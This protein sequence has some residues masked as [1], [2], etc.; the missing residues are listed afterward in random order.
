MSVVRRIAH[1]AHIG[2]L[3]ARRRILR[4]L[5]IKKKDTGMGRGGGWKKKERSDYL[6]DRSSSSGGTGGGSR[7]WGMLA[8]LRARQESPY[9]GRGGR[10]H[11]ELLQDHTLFLSGLEG[12][13]NRRRM[14]MT[15]NGVLPD[16]WL[17]LQKVE[18]VT[19]HTQE[20]RGL[21]YVRIRRLSPGSTALRAPSRGA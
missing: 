16:G 6:S 8:V 20:R 13:R 15:M 7:R 21:R 2:P 11:H 18:G 14:M 1:D 19:L 3:V 10:C 4:L 5:L 17:C 12:R 9:S